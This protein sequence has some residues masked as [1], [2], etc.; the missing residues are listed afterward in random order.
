MTNNA[1]DHKSNRIGAGRL[2]KKQAVFFYPI[3]Q[4]T[5]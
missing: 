2:L 3:F 1:A 4:K 5:R